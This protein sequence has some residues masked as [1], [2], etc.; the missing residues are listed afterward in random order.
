MYMMLFTT[1]EVGLERTYGSGVNE[2]QLSF[3]GKYA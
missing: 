1:L 2:I 3:A